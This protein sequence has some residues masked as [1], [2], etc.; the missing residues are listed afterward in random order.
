MPKTSEMIE[1][2]YLKKEDVGEDG[3]VVT[4]V[5]LEKVNV[6][7]K[8]AKAE[9]KWTMQFREFDKPMVLGPTN[10]RLAEK[11]LDSDDT[12]NWIGKKIV[13]FNDPNI[14]FGGEV[15]GGIRLKAHRVAAPPRELPPTKSSQVDK[16][17]DDI[18]F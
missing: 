8:D 6:A 7:K 2:P 14:T 9:Y 3:T 17:D 1:S 10:I 11:A 16:L 4:I 18:P 13:A 5:S 12:A 15:T